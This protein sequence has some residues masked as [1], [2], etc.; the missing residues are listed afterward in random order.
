MTRAFGLKEAGMT[1]ANHVFRR[2]A[3]YTW[4]RRIPEV[5]CQGERSAALQLSLKTFA[6]LEASAS[7][8]LR[9]KR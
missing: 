9:R 6:R 3:I 1:V 5:A 7:R 2:G 8:R 4:R